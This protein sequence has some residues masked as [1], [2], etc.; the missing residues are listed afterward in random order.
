MRIVFAQVGSVNWNG[1][2]SGFSSVGPTSDGRIKP[3]LSSMGEGSYVCNPGFSFGSGNG[4]SYATPIL[5]GAVACLWQA[6]PTKTNMQ[7]LAAL[8]ATASQ[9]ATPNNSYG[10]GIPNMCAA[11]NLLNGTTIGLTALEKS[12]NFKLFPNPAQHNISFSLNQK[13]ESIEVLDI[14]GKSVLTNF[15]MIDSNKFKVDL[16]NLDNGVYFI[17]IKTA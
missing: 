4:T 10:W 6:N 5:A 3:D 11:H 7:I 13:P 16:G 15:V 9:S 17:F 8:K 14:L 12:L 1:V 2:H